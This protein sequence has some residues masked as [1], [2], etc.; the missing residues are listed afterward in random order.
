MVVGKVEGLFPAPVELELADNGCSV[1]FMDTS[2][3]NNLRT[4]SA[5]DIGEKASQ[6]HE[7]GRSVQLI[8]WL[9]LLFKDFYGTIPV[10]DI[11]T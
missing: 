1:E 8:L 9:N 10:V 3:K 4:A 11:N 7:R 5:F 2:E 6:L